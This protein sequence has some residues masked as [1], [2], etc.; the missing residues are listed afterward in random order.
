MLDHFGSSNPRDY[1]A[2]LHDP[3]AAFMS[4]DHFIFLKGG[5]VLEVKEGKAPWDDDFLSDVYG[6]PIKTIPFQDRSIVVPF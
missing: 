2:V 1:L 5:R 3:N 6:T 4:G